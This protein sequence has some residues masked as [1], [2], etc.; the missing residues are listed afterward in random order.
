GG[1]GGAAPL[2]M[3]PALG[4]PVRAPVAQRGPFRVEAVLIGFAG[5]SAEVGSAG[6]AS[7]E[8]AAAERHKTPSSVATP[9]RRPPVAT[10]IPCPPRRR[11]LLG[12]RRSN[13]ALREPFP[14]ASC[15]RGASALRA[16]PM[17]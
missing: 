8:D 9:P 17:P 13:S 1:G 15:G 12:A 7:C 10:F 14:S 3:V 6:L 11:A 2:L 5:A 4:A 16:A